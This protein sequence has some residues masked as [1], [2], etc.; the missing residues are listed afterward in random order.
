[1]GKETGVR[2]VYFSYGEQE[3]EYL[4]RKDKRLGAVI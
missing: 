4:R 1:M 2:G 3:T